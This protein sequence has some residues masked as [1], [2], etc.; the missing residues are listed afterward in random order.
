M[1]LAHSPEQAV[2][3]PASK[4][5]SGS[6]VSESGLMEA[7][8]PLLSGE[9]QV[10]MRPLGRNKTEAGGDYGLMIRCNQKQVCRPRNYFSRWLKPL[11]AVFLSLWTEQPLPDASDFDLLRT[12]CGM[13]VKEE[14]V[15]HRVNCILQGSR[16]AWICPVYKNL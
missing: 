10:Q 9:I 5:S 7:C 4:P 2:G 13:N 11:W 3:F 6:H 16:D 1:G 12:L 8:F 14:I 15:I